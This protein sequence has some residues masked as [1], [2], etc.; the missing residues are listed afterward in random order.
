M[1]LSELISQYRTTHDISQR[2]FA[3]QCG[4]SNGYIAMI[5]KNLNPKT[6]QPVV[7]TIPSLIKIANGMGMT[8]SELFDVVDD[9]PVSMRADDKSSEDAPFDLDRLPSPM[10]Q[11]IAVAYDQATAKEKNIVEM[12]LS[13]YLPAAEDRKAPVRFAA[14]SKDGTP[15][16][17][18]GADPNAP[19]PHPFVKGDDI[20]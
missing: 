18:T 1:K 19:I 15:V 4:V 14:Y 7:P 8:L 16:D 3:A 13:A 17:F 10:A 2:Q 9:M 5:E 11:K 12:I 6:G 20:P